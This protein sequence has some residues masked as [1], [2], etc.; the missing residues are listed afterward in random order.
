MREELSRRNFVAT[1]AATWVGLT[2]GHARGA[3]TGKPAALGGT[4][5]RKEPFP[6]WP[7]FDQSEEQELLDTVRSGRWFRGSG[8]NVAQFEAAYAA[9]MGA[10]HCV[11]TSSGTNALIA[12]MNALGVGA[13]DEVILPPYTF[14]ACVNAI[15]MLGAVPVFVDTNR[16]TF[17]ID[18]RKIEDAVMERTVAIMPVHLGGNAADV[19]AILAVA[20]QHKLAVIEDACQAHLGEWRGRKLGTFGDAGCFS[21]QA[22]KNLTGGEG[23]AILTNDDELADKCFAAQ[24]NGNLRRGAG[25]KARIR[26]SNFRMSEFHAGLVKAQMARL[27][28]QATTRDA[29][30]A[31][32]TKM[33]G[34]IPGIAPATPYDGC[35]RNAYHLYMFRYDKEQFANLPRARFLQTLA[36][37]GIPASTGYSPLNKEPFILDT[38]KSRGYRRA[39]PAERVSAWA[40]QNICPENDRLCKEA[41]WF[42]QNMLLADRAAMEQ[43]V[44]AVRKIAR[45]APDLARA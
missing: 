9:L 39:V 5:A 10:K 30:G 42:T 41:V 34:E 1:A 2:L 17:Q 45:Y 32:L 4:P 23:G 26:G 3:T 16:Q 33:L 40:E 18:A 44:E 25:A 21:F 31:Y 43:I 38:L 22:S 29:N 20:R 12:S 14:V 15:L 19:D 27:P 35:T 28:A 24:N 6:T 37:E 13:G 7:V 8:Q 11:A 36:A